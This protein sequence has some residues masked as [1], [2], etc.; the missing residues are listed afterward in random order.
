[1]LPRREGNGWKHREVIEVMRPRR[2]ER[3]NGGEI[4]RGRQNEDLDTLGR[5][6]LALSLVE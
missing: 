6:S 1:M 2:W 5:H 4:I 3:G